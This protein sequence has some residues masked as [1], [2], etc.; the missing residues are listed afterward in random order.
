M[1]RAAALPQALV[2]N[3][4]GQHAEGAILRGSFRSQTPRM[5]WSAK[6]R[7]S[8][9]TVQLKDLARQRHGPLLAVAVGCFVKRPREVARPEQY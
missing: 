8:V 7:F 9:G 3:D 4:Q 5:A 6:V 1:R 2:A